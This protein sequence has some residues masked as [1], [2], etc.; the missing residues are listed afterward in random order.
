M[1]W[2]PF[3]TASTGDL[4]PWRSGPTEDVW[5]EQGGGVGVGGRRRL[6]MS[7][8]EFIEKRIQLLYSVVSH[9][10]KCKKGGT[11]AGA[12]LQIRG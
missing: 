9:R 8:L 4:F 2:L 10:I 12:W 7:T 5:S 11:G 1:L 3:P 6:R